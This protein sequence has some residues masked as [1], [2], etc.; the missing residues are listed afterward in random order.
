MTRE[1]LLAEL[2]AVVALGEARRAAARDPFLIGVRPAAAD[3]M[4]SDEVHRLCEIQAALVPYAWEEREAAR[5]RVA[6][7]RAARRAARE[8][9]PSGG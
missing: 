2:D 9:T 5:A 7:K 1:E 8:N 4:T 6:V 3:W